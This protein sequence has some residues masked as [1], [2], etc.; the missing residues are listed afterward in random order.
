MFFRNNLV[1]YFVGALSLLILTSCGG[2]GPGGGVAEFKT[3]SI[4]ATALTPSLESD[5]LTGNTCSGSVS[6]G[7]TVSTDSVDVEITSTLYPG[8][9]SGLPVAIDSY[10]VQFAPDNSHSTEPP[11]ALAGLSGSTLGQTV[12]PNNALTIPVGVASQSMKFKLINDGVIPPC[13]AIIHAYF[14]TI[15]LSAVEVGS[16][17]RKNIGPIS[18][19][20]A[21]ADRI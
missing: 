10:S 2:E 12:Q 1:K 19:N 6:T 21:F 16:G 7:G 14:A 4:S 20:V 3:V 8:I 18:L 11:P 17:T 13:S 9:T 5:V 15:T